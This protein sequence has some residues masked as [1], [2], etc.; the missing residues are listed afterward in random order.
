MSTY[1][2]DILAY[3]GLFDLKTEKDRESQI[4]KDMKSPLLLLIAI[5]GNDDD[6]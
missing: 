2:S 5:K 1:K 3:S 6:G 4:D